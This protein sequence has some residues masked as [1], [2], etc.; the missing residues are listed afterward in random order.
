MK[1]RK[2]AGDIF[3]LDIIRYDVSLDSSRK[4]FT[5]F[6]IGI[7]HERIRFRGNE[8]IAF[9]FPFALRTEA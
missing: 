5:H 1:D 9:N 7:K 2:P 4:L 6:R 3:D 8:N